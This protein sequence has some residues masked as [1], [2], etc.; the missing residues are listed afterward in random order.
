[1]ECGGEHHFNIFSESEC[2]FVISRKKD[3]EEQ[4]AV[5]TFRE[6]LEKSV[7]DCDKDE[8]EKIT[9]GYDYYLDAFTFICSDEG[10]QG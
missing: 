9:S 7:E 10:K 5:E 2:I 3:G 6:C 8:G 1:M 4:S